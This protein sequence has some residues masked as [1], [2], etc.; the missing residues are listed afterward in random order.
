MRAALIRSSGM[1]WMNCRIRKMPNASM[2]NGVM[3]PWYV[4]SHPRLAIST[5]SGIIRTKNGTISVAS[6]ATNNVL[7]SGKRNLAKTYPTSGSNSRCASVMQPATT[8]LL[9]MKFPNGA[10]TNSSA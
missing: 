7:R 5:Y 1:G 3:S 9:T 2:R 6:S 10:R 8:R 4:S